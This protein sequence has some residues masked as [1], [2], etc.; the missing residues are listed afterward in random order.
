MRRGGGGVQHTV[1]E[2]IFFFWENGILC[3]FLLVLVKLG[4]DSFFC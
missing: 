4:F 1:E 2:L 3:I